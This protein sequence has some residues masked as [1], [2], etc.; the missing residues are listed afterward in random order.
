M[1]HY[2][3][4]VVVDDVSTS[5]CLEVDPL[6]RR[7][8]EELGSWLHTSRFVRPPL[9]SLARPRRCTCLL[10]AVEYGGR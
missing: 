9:S 7:D 3:G 5:F 6:R 4:R 1:A 10:R 2:G 8:V